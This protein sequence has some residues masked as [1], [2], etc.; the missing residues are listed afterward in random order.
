MAACALDSAGMTGDLA[1]RT[2]TAVVL[3]AVAL[4]AVWAGGAIFTTVVLAL[5]AG[6]MWEWSGLTLPDRSLI[7]RAG[8]TIGPPLFLGVLLLLPPYLDMPPVN[9]AALVFGLPAL[10]FLAAF[11]GRADHEQPAGRWLHI[12]WCAWFAPAVFAAIWLRDAYG[13][14]TLAWGF[15]VVWASDIGAYF[16]GR[17]IGGRKLAPRISPGK[18]VSGL[19]GGLAAAVAVGL[20]ASLLLDVE[21]PALA[22]AGAYAGVALVVAGAG[23]LGD[24]GES[25]LK[26]HAGVKDSGRLL[27]GHGGLFD[28]LDS[29]LFALP[30]FAYCVYL[31]GWPL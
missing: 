25:A 19:L 8:H 3:G 13:P 29:I 4:A 2:A 17:A 15:A 11:T 21:L 10:A 16:I 12:L 18:T 31:R 5:F 26:R 9:P 30:A 1:R 28:R 7:A 14:L 24:L 6:L 20:A 22:N 23:V 27:P